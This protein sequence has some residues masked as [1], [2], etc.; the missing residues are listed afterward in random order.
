MAR[1]VIDAWAES[2]RDWARHRISVAGELEPALCQLSGL[3]KGTEFPSFAEFVYHYLCGVGDLDQ[4]A[5]ERARRFW[6][7]EEPF[8]SDTLTPAAVVAFCKGAHAE[9][10]KLKG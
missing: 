4:A 2:G 3:L 9:R 6:E 5:R 1:E 7:T 8:D 10:Q